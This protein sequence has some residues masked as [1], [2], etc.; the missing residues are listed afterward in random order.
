[1][2]VMSTRERFRVFAN[3]A[4]LTLAAWFFSYAL[5]TPVSSEPRTQLAQVYATPSS[6]YDISSLSSGAT[7][8]KI[9]DHV[10]TA[11]CEPGY[12]YEI[13]LV[14]DFSQG[15]SSMYYAL[16]V[17]HTPP[18]ATPKEK[19]FPGIVRYKDLDDSTLSQTRKEGEGKNTIGDALGDK[20]HTPALIGES[21]RDSIDRLLNEL[22]KEDGLDTALYQGDP[23]RFP[24]AFEEYHPPELERKS[25]YS[26][27]E[28]RALAYDVRASAKTNL[29]SD[30][31]FS[32]LVAEQLACERAGGCAGLY[33]PELGVSQQQALDAQL[34]QQIS[35]QTL[36][37]LQ[38]RY[39][40]AD[41]SV[42]QLPG[43]ASKNIARISTLEGTMYYDTLTGRPFLQAGYEKSTGASFGVAKSLA[44]ISSDGSLKPVDP[45]GGAWLGEFPSAVDSRGKYDVFSEELF[46]TGVGEVEYRYVKIGLSAYP[47]IFW[48]EK[49]EDRESVAVTVRSFPSE[50]TNISTDTYKV[51]REQADRVYGIDNIEADVTRWTGGK[52]SFD[53]PW[54]FPQNVLLNA[55]HIP[56][57]LLT[58]LAPLTRAATLDAFGDEL[59]KYPPSFW[60][61]GGPVTI[62]TFS[63]MSEKEEKFK[64]GGYSI[65]WGDA[66]HIWV[67]TE[68]MGSYVPPYTLETLHHELAHYYDNFFPS[69]DMWGK[70]VYGDQYGYAYGGT[71]G[72]EAISLGKIPTLRPFGFAGPYG[73]AGGV[74]EDKAT[75]AGA[76]FMNPAVVFEA[77]KTDTILALKVQMIQGGYLQASSGEMDQTY[78][79]K[80]VPIDPSY[81]L[82]P[83]EDFGTTF[84]RSLLNRGK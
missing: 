29:L 66:P 54:E 10:L 71:S 11:K 37:E 60:K 28:I 16:K 55:P 51:L 64:V 76:L 45:N 19:L 20:I 8:N 12:E 31:S 32:A 52:V 67:K 14:R 70:T 83:R 2:S 81:N 30:P 46:G 41:S 23:L 74:L 80:L 7:G 15:A 33:V 44:L 73:Y 6:S 18:P 82:L 47:G 68:S 40:L 22:G 21:A 35:A 5:S 34:E 77:T 69:D 3:L 57:D 75:V 78:W 58:P 49:R 26:F 50:V 79:Q 48:G 53:R 72:A 84:V 36:Q 63:P 27:D 59:L 43:E 17:T 4:A 39:A 24:D 13:A 25:S 61:A 56:K 38:S 62:Y 65:N 9:D 42:A 1:M